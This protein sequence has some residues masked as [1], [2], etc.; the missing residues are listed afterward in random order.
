MQ[1]P[2]LRHAKLLRDLCGTEPC[3]AATRTTAQKLGASYSPTVDRH[4]THLVRVLPGDINRKVRTRCTRTRNC[5][6][7]VDFAAF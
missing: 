6:L 2:V 5:I 4:C 1:C 3:Y 7:V